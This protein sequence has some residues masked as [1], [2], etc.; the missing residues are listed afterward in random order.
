MTLVGWTSSALEWSK[1]E[2]DAEYEACLLLRFLAR[3]TAAWGAEADM[4]LVG[5]SDEL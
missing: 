4:T 2:D 3:L 5:G 1:D